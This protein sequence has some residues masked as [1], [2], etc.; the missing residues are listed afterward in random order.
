VAL[1]N[2][3]SRKVQVISRLAALV[4]EWLGSRRQGPWMLA[5]IAIAVL[6][7]GHRYHDIAYQIPLGEEWHSLWRAS[8]TPFEESSTAITRV[9][10]RLRSTVPALATR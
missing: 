10:R 9:P 4:T 7:L 1:S 6:G 5:M 8:T 3:E 2:A